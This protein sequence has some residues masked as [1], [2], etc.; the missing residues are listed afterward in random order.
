M[1]P[2][3]G[4]FYLAS[5]QLHLDS[6]NGRIHMKHGR[7]RQI[8]RRR[9]FISYVLAYSKHEITYTIYTFPSP[10]FGFINGFARIPYVLTNMS[11]TLTRQLTDMPSLPTCLTLSLNK[12][13][14]QMHQQNIKYGHEYG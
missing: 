9:I 13:F 12:I 10:Y 6:E 11:Q 14:M 7:H 3:I 4:H 5:S 8:Y 1:T 2:L